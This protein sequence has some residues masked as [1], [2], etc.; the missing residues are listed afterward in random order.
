MIPTLI[1]DTTLQLMSDQRILPGD[2]L[3]ETS[4]SFVV[5]DNATVIGTDATTGFS[6]YL[7]ET[8]TGLTVAHGQ[9]EALYTVR[10]DACWQNGDPVTLL[11]VIH[12]APTS[13]MV[14]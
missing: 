14:P 11:S 12:F 5:V 8:A 2:R 6:V 10:A 1:G 4:T 9:E 13:Y 7:V 3:Y